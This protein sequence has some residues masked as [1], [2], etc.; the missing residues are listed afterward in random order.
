MTNNL[1]EFYGVVAGIA[2]RLHAAK[3][4]AESY[5][6]AAKAMALEWKE[7]SFWPLSSDET[8]TVTVY[9]LDTDGAVKRCEV[10]VRVRVDADARDASREVPEPVRHMLRQPSVA[11]VASP[12]GGK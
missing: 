4:R 1:H 5:T 3:A 7:G 10:R 2:G 6:D 12:A 11:S 9:V 8:E